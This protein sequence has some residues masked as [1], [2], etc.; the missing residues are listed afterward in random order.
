[1][2]G[3]LF[4]VAAVTVIPAY[5]WHQWAVLTGRYERWSRRR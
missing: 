4:V 3:V 2:A 5:V 1:M